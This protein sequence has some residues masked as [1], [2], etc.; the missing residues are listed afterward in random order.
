MAFRD[1][2][3]TKVFKNVQHYSS[4]IENNLLSVASDLQNTNVLYSWD[5]L[6]NPALFTFNE[7]R[8]RD[9]IYAGNSGI[10]F[11]FVTFKAVRAL[12][13]RFQIKGILLCLLS[14]V[15]SANDVIAVIDVSKKVNPKL[16]EK[17]KNVFKLLADQYEI[18]PTKTRFGVVS[19]SSSPTTTLDLNEGTQRSTIGNIISA[20]N[21]QSES[22]RLSLAL[23]RVIRILLSR[24]YA[25]P[26]RRNIPVKV[27]IFSSDLTEDAIE[28]AAKS[29]DDIAKQNVDLYFLA[30]SNNYEARDD[31]ISALPNA[32]N[33]ISSSEDDL[34]GEPFTSLVNR[35]SEKSGMLTKFQKSQNL[36]YCNFIY[37]I[38]PLLVSSIIYVTAAPCNH[39]K[40]ARALFTIAAC[41]YKK[42]IFNAK[43][44][45]LLQLLQRNWTLVS[46]SVDPMV[47]V[48]EISTC[49]RRLRKRSLNRLKYQKTQYE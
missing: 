25:E 5:I 34:F 16:L 41:N 9:I 10:L 39:P 19:Y 44:I 7:I 14:G 38:H 12:L 13:K 1:S 42:L 32:V 3:Q 2:L 36:I 29:L 33:V 27:I 48:V 40:P 21:L 8:S 30:I 6:K 35:I 49:K 31:A 45:I 28:R 23:Q 18:G 17:V 4:A 24:S 47:N 26:S 11:S 15:D 43:L 22:P 20:L 46:L 37:S